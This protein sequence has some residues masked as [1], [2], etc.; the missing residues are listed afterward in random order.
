MLRATVVRGV[1]TRCAFLILAKLI[2]KGLKSSILA[3]CEARRCLDGANALPHRSAT[4]TLHCK[5]LIVFDANALID[6][7]LDLGLGHVPIAF[8]AVV[9]PNVDA[10]HRVV[11]ILVALDSMP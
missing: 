8:G 5:Q 2:N 11:F 4:R 10:Q 1:I 7:R 9:E 3:D 6:S